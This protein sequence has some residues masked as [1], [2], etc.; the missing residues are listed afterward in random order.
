MILN[1]MCYN[2]RPENLWFTIKGSLRRDPFK[3]PLFKTNL[4]SFSLN[5]FLFDDLHLS[6]YH[7]NYFYKNNNNLIKTFNV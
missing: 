6:P 5:S 3:T 1:L 7:F 2:H 4:E